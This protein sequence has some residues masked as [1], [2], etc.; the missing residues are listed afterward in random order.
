[1]KLL[2]LPAMPFGVDVTLP[3]EEG[4]T[5]QDVKKPAIYFGRMLD[6]HAD[7][8]C[9]VHVAGEQYLRAVHPS[10]VSEVAS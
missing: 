6:E 8:V 4:A 10:R 7:E 9:V 2:A 1:M 5:K 3:P